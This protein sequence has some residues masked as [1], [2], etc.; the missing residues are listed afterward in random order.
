MATPVHK[1]FID[2]L[3][4][5]RAPKPDITDEVDAELDG[6]LE[7]LTRSLQEHEDVS[8]E[9]RRRQS[10]GGLRVV[11]VPVASD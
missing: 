3:L 7:R 4:G 10:S 11:L 5:R 6:A 1:S 9:V 8:R 2:G